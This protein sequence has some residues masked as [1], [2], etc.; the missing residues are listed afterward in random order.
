M[1]KLF[2]PLLLSF[3]AILL[4]YV[5]VRFLVWQVP[6]NLADLLSDSETNIDDL[7]KISEAYT[8][9][10]SYLAGLGDF[11]RLRWGQSELYH[12]TF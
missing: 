5:F 6:G 1:R 8:H 2:R 3:F 4:S 11:F 12:D 10:T 7:K 9:E